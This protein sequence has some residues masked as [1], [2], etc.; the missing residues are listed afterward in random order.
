MI[1][2]PTSVKLNR[3]KGSWKNRFN[4]IPNAL[5]LI[6]IFL[7]LG[8]LL[9]LH[10][11]YLFAC[12]VVVI[13][14]TD[15]ADGYIA[16]TCNWVSALGAQLD[17][18]AD[19]FFYAVVGGILYLEYEWLLVDNVVWC[20]ICVFLKTATVILSKIKNG[21]VQFIHTLGNK[22]AGLFA[23]IAT[24]ILPFGVVPELFTFVCIVG[25][26]AAAEELA[27]VWFYRTVDVNQ[28]SILCKNG[29]S[30]RA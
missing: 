6:R 17:S 24:V 22:L 3:R 12:L 14:I 30:N 27:I 8:L 9:T 13:G 7:S 18:L 19:L 23:F 2:M 28:R 20:L 29:E 4:W 21:K 25:M 15:V 26:I 10:R 5:S 16:R 11:E 1:L